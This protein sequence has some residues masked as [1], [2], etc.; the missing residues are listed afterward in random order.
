MRRTTVANWPSP[1][2]ATSWIRRTSGAR[3]TRSRPDG[4]RLEEARGALRSHQIDLSRIPSRAGL[5]VL[6]PILFRQDAANCRLGDTVDQDLEF[7]ITE[8]PRAPT[9]G[10][11]GPDQ[12]GQFQPERVR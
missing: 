4:L 10:A 12:I 2:A 5:L 11:V 6:G 1:S 3:T 7:G 9:R 8:L